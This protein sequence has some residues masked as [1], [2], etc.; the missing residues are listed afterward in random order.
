MTR[1][2]QVEV[3]DATRAIGLAL[4]QFLKDAK[5]A[6]KDGWQPGQDLPVVLSSF[7]GNF[8]PQLGKLPEIQKD[9]QDLA[10]FIAALLLTGKDVADA[11]L[12]KV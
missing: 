2:E 6:L 12:E 7:V 9:S 10:P 8:L 11:L 4:A 1:I 3:S 5:I